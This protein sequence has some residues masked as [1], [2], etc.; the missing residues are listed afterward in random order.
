MSR[1]KSKN[2]WPELFIRSR[3]HSLGYRFRLHKKGL[4]G[5]PD[6]VLKKYKTVIFINGCFWHGHTCPRGKLPNKNHAFWLEKI[7][8]NKARDKENIEE[9]ELL[10]WNVIIIW[11]CES[12]NKK[13]SEEVIERIIYSLVHIP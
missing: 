5:H 8:K 3:L 4:P 6:I 9:L 7:E 2:T 11:T 12:K 10:G 13:R 1:V